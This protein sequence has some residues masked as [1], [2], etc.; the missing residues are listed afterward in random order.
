MKIFEASEADIEAW[1]E[2][3]QD[4]WPGPDEEHLTEMRDILSSDSQIAFL[5]AD[6]ENKAIG[7]IEGAVYL[8][9]PQPYGYV[10]GWFILPEY[11]RQGLGGQLLGRLEEWILHQG[12]A[13][14]L[15]DTIP[16]EYPLSPKAHAKYGYRKFRT[17]QI[18]IKE[19]EEKD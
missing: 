13:L 1:L 10:E 12:I 11:R 8:K 4:L 7:L 16:E 15:S 5:M 9:S 14:S 3:R 19:L 2:L 18:F 17:M 6:P